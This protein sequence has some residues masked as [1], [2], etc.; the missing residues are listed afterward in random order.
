MI[1]IA[2]QNNHLKALIS[3]SRKSVDQISFETGIKQSQLKSYVL[4]ERIKEADRIILTHYFKTNRAYLSDVWSIKVDEAYLSRFKSIFKD[5]EHLFT[6]NLSGVFED[7]ANC[8]YN[9][10]VQCIE[11]K[12]L[13]NNTTAKKF[14]N[15]LQYRRI[16]G[17]IIVTIADDDLI[18]DSLREYNEIIRHY[19]GSNGQYRPVETF[20]DKKVE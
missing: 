4:G 10:W 2:K 11:F 18:F 17:K 16:E 12:A 13:K 15:S 20:K 9:Y 1:N 14:F 3:K 8:F 19:Y 6:L 5:P 7:E